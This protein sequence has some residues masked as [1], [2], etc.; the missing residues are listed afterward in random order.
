VISDQA[1]NE[2]L[3][4]LSHGQEW[5]AYNSM[6]YFMETGDVFMFRH[7]E[8]AD[9]FAMNNISEYDLFAVIKVNSIR[10]VM[11]KLVYGEALKERMSYLLTQNNNV[12]NEKN[13]DYLSN[14]LKYSGFGDELNE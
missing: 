9:E 4:G 2:I 3:T 14:Q 5:L 13:Y 6:N 11:E 1:M 7:E 8:E 10:D 12:M